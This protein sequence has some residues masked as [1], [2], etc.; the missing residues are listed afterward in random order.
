MQRT[1][2]GSSCVMTLSQVSE[3]L[4]ITFCLFVVDL[5][6]WS[7]VSFCCLVVRVVSLLLCLQGRFD[8]LCRPFCVFAIDLCLTA[9][10]LHLVGCFASLSGNFA[11]F[12]DHLCFVCLCSCVIGFPN[13]FYPPTQVQGSRKSTQ[14][15]PAG[16]FLLVWDARFEFIPLTLQQKHPLG[17]ELT[18]LLF[19]ISLGTS[20]FHT[21]RWLKW[22][23]MEVL[24]IHFVKF[25]FQSSPQTQTSVRS[26]RS[27]S[28]WSSWWS[29]TQQTEITHRSWLMKFK[30]MFDLLHKTK[31]PHIWRLASCKIYLNQNLLLFSCD[32]SELIFSLK[33]NERLIKCV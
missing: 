5:I 6:D 13:R 22:R 1:Q 15:S 26:G 21:S 28:A 27:A 9:V 25:S 4:R 29:V 31:R 14:N 30:I 18:F 19:N 20:Y 3:A 17:S 7:L 10:K 23:Y 8:S 2:T 16:W 11:S 12:S 24:I 33:D 32:S